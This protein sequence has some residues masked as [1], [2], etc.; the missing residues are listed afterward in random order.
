MFVRKGGSVME[1]PVEDDSDCYLALKRLRDEDD[2]ILS[3]DEMKK[4]LGIPE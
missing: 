2:E 3:S 1:K 4:L